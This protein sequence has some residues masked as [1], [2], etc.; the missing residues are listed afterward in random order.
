MIDRAARNIGLTF[1]LAGVILNPWTLARLFLSGGRVETL[2]SVCFILLA[3]LYCVGAGVWFLVKGRSLSG[4]MVL[5]SLVIFMIVPAGIEGG[6]QAVRFLQ[7]QFLSNGRDGRLSLS[8]YRGKPWAPALFAEQR[9]LVVSFE[10]Y[11]GWRTQEFH[12]RYLNIDPDRTRR[13]VNPIPEGRGPVMNV[14]MFG[15][16]TMWGAYVRDSSTI[17]SNVSLKSPHS[18]LSIRAVNLAEQGYN[19]TQ[20]VIQLTLLLR[21]GERPDFALFYEGFNDIGAAEAY[22]RAGVTSLYYEINELLESRRSGFLGQVGF[23]AGD[24][25]VRKSMLYKSVARITQVLGNASVRPEGVPEYSAKDLD[26]LSRGIAREYRM[27]FG[28]LDSL[29]KQFGFRYACVL[30]PGLF[31]K[32]SV[33]PEEEGSDLRA[34]DPQLRSLFLRT[35]AA[36]REE[37]FPRIY[38][39]TK[40]FDGHPETVFIDV[41]HVSEEGNALIADSLLQILHPPRLL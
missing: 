28:V 9:A 7:S 41:C 38:D 35:Y 4:K 19:F 36:L 2:P 1:V 5:F 39:F 21:L 32:A 30:Q 40:L 33:N 16:S 20:G 10:Q 14:L 3:D 15:G 18:G 27:N 24:L 13:T 22:G 25:I 29:S 8:C 12:G 31:T 17:P 26:S 6:L 11:L 34:R 23:A 37:H